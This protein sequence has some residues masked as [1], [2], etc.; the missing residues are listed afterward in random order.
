VVFKQGYV[1]SPVCSPSRAGMLTGRYQSKFGY[2]MNPSED[3]P[4]YDH[5]AQ[6]LTVGQT[7]IGDRLAARGYKTGLIGKWHLGDQ[8]QFNPTHRGFQEFWGFLGGGHNYFETAKH[9]E[10]YTVKIESNYKQLAPI[11]Y[12]TDDIGNEAADFVARHAGEPFCLFA[13]FNAP[14][15]PLQALDTDLQRYA[16][17]PDK[18]RRTYCAMVDALDRNVGK[19]LDALDQHGLASN[20]I[21]A[22]LSDNG[23]VPTYNYSCNAPLN[24]SKGTMLEGGIRVPFVLRWPARLKPQEYSMPVISLD[25]AATFLKL[26]GAPIKPEDQLDGVDLLPFLTG[27]NTNR[28]HQNLVWHFNIHTAWRDGDLK[29]IRIPDRLP[30]LYDVA[31]DRS[32]QHDLMLHNVETTQALLKKLSVWENKNPYPRFT[33]GPSWRSFQLSLYDLQYQLTQPAPDEVPRVIRPGKEKQVTS[34]ANQTR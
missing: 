11:T 15:C 4:G 22:F 33:E 5:A 28:P 29:V 1:T 26:A 8:P 9:D 17:I 16:H 30:M 27:A 14:H 10:E 25:L 2:E 3:V 18:N 23:G 31:A 12:L 19:I 7:T 13:T 34:A 6:G 20:T 24:G 21:V 32:E